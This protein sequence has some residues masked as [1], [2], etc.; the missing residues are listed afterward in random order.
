MVKSLK[1][2]GSIHMIKYEKELWDKN[3][4]VGGIDE[5]GRGCIAGPLVVCSVVLPKNY[6]H[7]DINDSKSISEKRRQDLY[8][9]ILEDAL[10]IDV[11]VINEVTVDDLNIYQATKTAMESLIS[12]SNIDNFLVDAMPINSDKSVQSLIK[13][14][15]LSIS[16]AAASIVAKVIRDEIMMYLDD[17]YPEYGFKNHKG[18]ATKLHKEKLKEY[19][20]LDFHR[21]SYKPVYEILNEQLSLW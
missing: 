1:L 12:T 3:Q 17:A 7:E 6:F 5:V 4:L 19:G 11:R 15:T 2:V 13:G 10:M 9:L 21:R 20:V 14:D 8:E 16:I 18:Y